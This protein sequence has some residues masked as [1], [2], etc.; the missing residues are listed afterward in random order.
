M[1]RT[2]FF[3]D[4]DPTVGVASAAI[5]FTY[6]TQQISSRRPEIWSEII[7]WIA[8]P[9]IF[10]QFGRSRST[11]PLTSVPFSEAQIRK[12]S[13]IPQWIFA[14]AVAVACLYRAESSIVTLFPVLTPLFLI[15]QRYLGWESPLST[16]SECWPFSTLISSIWGAASVA[17]VACL[18]LFNR[19]LP[20]SALSAI[21]VVSLLIVYLLLTPRPSNGVQP[22]PLVDAEASIIPLS[23]KVVVFLLVALT[24]QTAAFGFL[25]SD[26]VPTLLLGL[27]KALSWFFMIRTAQ[28]TSWCIATTIGTF[29]I[30]STRNPF[31][32]SSEAQ[33][34]THLVVSLASLGQTIHFVPKQA[35]GR[36][37]IWAF[38]I[39][40]LAPYVSNVL[41]IRRAQLVAPKS[42]GNSRTH[43]VEALAHHAKTDFDALLRNQSASYPAAHHEYRRRYGIEPPPGF[44]AWYE[45]ALSH[46]SPIID[47][48]DTIY[49][50]VSPFWKM[51]GQEFGDM[52][53]KMRKAPQSEVWLC[54][55]SAKEAKTRCEHPHRSYDRHYSLL[56]DT[57]LGDLKGVLPD[58]QFLVNHFD[59]PRVVIPLSHDSLDQKPF[60]FTDMSK[61]STW[62]KITASC[63]ESHRK[64]GDAYPE[65]YTETFDLPFVKNQFSAM[66]LCQ[67]EEYRNM[68]GFLMSPKTFRLVEGLVPILSTGAPSS[69]GDIL[70]PS[71]AYIEEEFQYDDARDPEWDR[72]TN[73]LYWAGSTT[74]G[75]ALDDQWRNQQRQRFVALAQNLGHQQHSYLREN[76]GLVERVKSSF[77]NSRLF[78]VAFTR[79][80]QCDKPYCRDQRTYF[81]TRSWVDKDEGLRSR[82]VFDMDGNGISG[83]YYKLLASNS[84]PLKQTIFREWHDE[85]L[86]SWVHYVPVSQSLEELPE[87][88]FHLTSTED[89]QRTAKEIATR[90]KEW[91]SRAFRDVDMTIYTY[92]LMLELARLQDPTRKAS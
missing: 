13:S 39:L 26:I 11:T 88:V 37:I 44:E 3:N 87:L 23:I 84:A 55:F 5:F 68:H 17:A 19:D 86:M 33:T 8:L 75:F 51:S 63:A 64:T 1:M 58:V 28:N 36:A 78:D 38:F 35:K 40:S 85:R 10:K 14:V 12:V 82:L 72:K 45:F 79:I 90:G 25:S 91:F 22:L 52:M 69:M 15:A 4:V 21:P 53:R 80:F 56:F 32:Q 54:T 59:E 27:A 62:D 66:D 7:C 73:N 48:Y 47:E 89:G 83:R 18:S 20:G 31:V 34:L 42:F 61:K 77:L 6:L 81:N 30:T 41:S 49:D 74:G 71:P 43:P 67:H 16:I 76:K 29:A 9:F 57:L 65:H 60:R 2:P 50:A 46:H 70:F 24:V 92:R